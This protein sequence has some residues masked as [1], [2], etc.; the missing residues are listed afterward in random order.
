MQADSA[1]SFPCRVR[2]TRG[3]EPGSGVLYNKLSSVYSKKGTRRQRAQSRSNA[4]HLYLHDMARRDG[5]LY[6]SAA[7]NV[8]NMNQTRRKIFLSQGQLYSMDV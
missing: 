1:A 8:M 4:D 3:T 6:G 5:P 2:S 7:V